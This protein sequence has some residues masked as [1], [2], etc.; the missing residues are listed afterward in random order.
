MNAPPTRKADI[1]HAVVGF[2]TVDE[3][4]R[5]ERVR[6]LHEEV[7]PITSS[8]PGFVSGYWMH[9]PETGKSH[10]TI[11]F[12]DRESA[13]RFKSVVEARSR[14]AAQVGTADILAV[15]DV[16]AHAQAASPESVR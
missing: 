6:G 9:D 16:E 14:R 8:Q 13:D 4:L 3:A 7:I 5:A 12:D 11:V 15:V 2:W 1:M 10:T